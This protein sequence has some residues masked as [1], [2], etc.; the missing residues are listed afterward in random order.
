MSLERKLRSWTF[1]A[2]LNPRVIETRRWL[3]EKKR[4]L[5]GARHVVSVFLQLDDPYSYILS[6]YLPHVAKNYD[7]DLRVYL[8][9]ARGGEYQPAPDMVPEYAAADCVRL[10]GELGVPFLDKGSLPPTEHRAAL[11][12]AVAALAGSDEFDN[13]LFQALAV[14]WRGD[15]AAAAQMSSIPGIAGKAREVVAHSME[16]QHKLGH[17]N[18]AMLNYGDEWY[19]GVDRLHY[20]LA[21]LDKLGVAAS[22]VP[23]PVLVSIRQA[24]KMSLPIKP[25]AMARDLPPIEVFHS[26]RSPYS[27][28]CLQRTYDIAD[29]FGVELKLRPV[30]PMVMR[31]MK[32]PRPKLLYIAM[33]TAREARRLSIA[34]GKMAD[35]VGPGVER[36]MAV[37]RYAESEHRARDFLLNAGI[38]IWSEAVDIATD[39]GMRKVTGRSGLFWPDVEKAMQGDAWRA[40]IEANR[41]SM[42]ESG[43]WGVPTIRMGDL[44]LWGQDRDWMLARHIEELCDTGEGILV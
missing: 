43:A 10:A 20:L 32:V 17:Y 31:G 24:M 4:R 36:F 11:S 1:N 16:L 13:E 3:I 38:A 44:V 30:L 23:D 21:R 2:I 39:R 26:P 27:Y 42:M 12:D 18:S 40:E 29:A 41:D 14:Y 35:P 28:L 5:T 9:E 7:I 25:P 22:E 19:W 33:D 34:F 15:S 8:S 6:H 37:Y